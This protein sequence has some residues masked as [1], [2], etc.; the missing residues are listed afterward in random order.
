MKS[1]F[2]FSPDKDAGYVDHCTQRALAIIHDQKAQ[3]A[4]EEISD[5]LWRSLNV[6]RAEIDV[7][8]KKHEII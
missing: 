3:K 8:L 6:T 2:R 5:C 7:I 4:I 1:V